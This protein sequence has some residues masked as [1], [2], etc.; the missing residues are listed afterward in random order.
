M[1]WTPFH[2]IGKILL[3]GY[4][5]YLFL[6]FQ[7]IFRLI[8]YYFITIYFV[9]YRITSLEDELVKSNDA[10]KSEK[11]VEKKTNLVNWIHNVEGVLLSE[12]PVINSISIMEAQLKRFKVSL[13]SV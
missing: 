2:T 3:S 7:E 6:Y 13:F 9:Y 11:F 4:D 10:S 8:F 1:K 12:H 5:S